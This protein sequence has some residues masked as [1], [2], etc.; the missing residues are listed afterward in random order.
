MLRGRKKRRRGRN[1]WVWISLLP[2]GLGA[3]APMVAGDRVG[4]RR[5]IALGLL[6]P[7][8]SL[9]GW[10]LSAVSN[11]SHEPPLTGLLML[12]G[13]VGGIVTSLVIRPEYQARLS[14]MPPAEHHWPQPTARSLQWSV[15]YALVAFVIT[16]GGVALLG[17]LFDALGVHVSVGVGVLIVDATLLGAL[18]PL[19]RRRGLSLPDLG[20]R[21]TLAMRS[22]GLALLVLVAYVVFAALYTLA[23]IGHSERHSADVLSQ[24]KHL[25][26]VEVVIAVVAASLSAPIVEEIFFRGLIFRSLRNRLPLPWAALAAGCLFGL[27]HI[28]GYPLVTLPVKAVFGVLACLLYERTGSIL[29][30]IAVHSFVDA[31]AIDVALTGND[32]IVLMVFGAL[33][34]A[35]VL[36]WTVG[37]LVRPVRPP[38]PAQ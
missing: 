24:V 13:W 27:V 29:P 6:W 28:I 36:R 19:A 34:A 17:L 10:I 25:G 37:T 32:N 11:P 16:F 18:V 4:V 33:I 7:A 21:P 26:T 31:T 35:I 14:Q 5:W 30:G 2:L 38:A 1:G 8:V 23:C 20:L 9:A 22:L 12:S 15:R 3:W